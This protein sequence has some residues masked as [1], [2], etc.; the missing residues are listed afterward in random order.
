MADRP[1]RSRGALDRALDRPL[2]ALQAAISSDAAIKAIMALLQ[3]AVSCDFVGAFFR[4]EAHADG[5]VPYRMI[6]TRGRDFGP[7][8]RDGSLFRDHP[9][10]PKLMANPGIK[11]ITTREILP[12]D[13]ILHR[14]GFYRDAM[15]VIGFRHS[16]AIYFWE[17]P[18]QMPEAVFSPSRAEG[19]PDFTDEDMAVLDRLYPQIDAALRRVRAIEQERTLRGELRALVDPTRPI[20]VLHWNLSVAAANRAARELCA[21][22]NQGDAN[23]RL[24]PPPF[25]L[26]PS[27]RDACLELKKRWSLSL[28][29]RPATGTA[30]KLTVR[31]PDRTRLSATVSLHAQHTAPLGKP[32]FLIEFETPEQTTRANQPHEE[33]HRGR[34]TLS[35]RELIRFVREG[36][37]NQEIALETGKALGSVKNA[38]SALFGK[39]GVHSRSALI[40]RIGSSALLLA[41][42]IC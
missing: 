31:H 35:E 14:S 28:Q 37:S 1:L 8:L 19:Q 6:D 3:R 17:D 24:K 33:P 34:F 32:G 40:A 42:L 11:F 7:Q 9:A 30:E 13:E 10:A 2:I 18:P 16:I 27:L 21:Q 36:K 26:P 15:Q 29:Q 39:V 22:W 5:A 12:P 38:F 23:P 4:I 25:C 20:C 41:E